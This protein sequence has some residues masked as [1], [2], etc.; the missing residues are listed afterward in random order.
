MSIENNFG[1]DLS[2]RGSADNLSSEELKEHEE[3]MNKLREEVGHMGENASEDV[4]DDHLEAA[5]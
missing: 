3:K 4:P 2:A 5:A 1:E